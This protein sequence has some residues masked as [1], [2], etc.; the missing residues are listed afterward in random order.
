MMSD[1]TLLDFF[2]FMIP[3]NSDT[4]SLTHALAHYSFPFPNHKILI[5][6][7]NH[8]M[9]LFVSLFCFVPCSFLILF[10]N[11][12]TNLSSCCESTHEHEEESEGCFL[13]A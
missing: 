10:T 7:Y 4:N 2:F 5:L 12:L 3:D 11:L 6:L 1:I 9:A 13:Y 8:S